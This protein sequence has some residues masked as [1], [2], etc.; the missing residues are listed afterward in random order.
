MTFAVGKGN[1][2]HLQPQH[3]E[4]MEVLA[5]ATSIWV[6]GLGE[7]DREDPSGHPDGVDLPL[8]PC[9]QS[10]LNSDE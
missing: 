8:A 5:I 6:R 2:T 1:E 9:F 3:L 4:S 10:R 7:V